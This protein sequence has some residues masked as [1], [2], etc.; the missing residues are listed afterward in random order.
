[1][2]KMMRYQVIVSIMPEIKDNG[3]VWI[4]GQVGTTF[5]VKVDEKVFVPGHEEGQPIDYWLDG[6]C[7]CV[8]LHSPDQN[9][10]IARLFPMSLEATHP[11]TLFNGFNK[12]KHADVKVVTYEDEGVAEKIFTG[13]EYTKDNIQNLNRDAF[14][15]LAGLSV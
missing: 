15:Q 3:K 7:L 1:M 10:R 9:I 2:S 11:A 14:W 5:A 12:T 6:D 13:E 8:D 4:R